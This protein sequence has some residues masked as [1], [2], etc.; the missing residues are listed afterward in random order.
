MIGTWEAIRLVTEREVRDRVRTRAFLISTVLFVLVGV[1][2]I[3]IPAI[4]K[5]LPKPSYDVGL[6]GR[7]SQP[8]RQTIVDL[9]PTV[10]GTVRLRQ[11]SSSDAARS[12]LAS[13]ALD[14]AIV[15]SRT[16][17]VDRIPSD[18]T[19]GLVRLA[20]SASQAVQIQTTLENEGLSPQQ[21]ASALRSPPLPVE[22]VQPTSKDVSGRRTVAFIGILFL[23]I[24][25]VTYG[26]IL[27][28]GVVE[29]KSSRIVEIL[30]STLRPYQLLAGKVLGIGVVGLGQLLTVGAAAL[31]AS[32]ATGGNVLPSG[33]GLTI[34]AAIMWFVL[35]YAFY[36]CAYAAAGSMGSRTQDV[37]STV[38]PLQFILLLTYLL[39]ISAL[40]S[41]DS[42]L[43]RVLSFFPPTAPMIMLARA[44]VGQVAWWEVPLSVALV[45]V[46]TYALIRVAGGVYAR[47]ILRTG[48]RI[49]L[50]Q[51][52]R[53]APA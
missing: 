8:V 21:A 36:S 18:P 1:A 19:S 43:V 37:Q 34:A 30:L 4:L 38:A 5:S 17:L 33:G 2:A 35:G 11:Q 48:P 6:V 20:A 52:L 28:T 25:I 53:M 41:P 42:T 7:Y 26:G 45:L 51:A 49:K 3:V 40:S 39:G 16:I 22:A 27:A 29:E 24:A 47:S 13:G 32:V 10:G 44:A 12:A 15:D 23:Y 46:G 50:R 9:G 31:I 14:L